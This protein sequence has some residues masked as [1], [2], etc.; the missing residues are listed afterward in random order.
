MTRWQIGNRNLFINVLTLTFLSREWPETGWLTPESP[1]LNVGNHPCVMPSLSRKRIEM[2]QTV[3]WVTFSFISMRKRYKFK[4]TRCL[5]TRTITFVWDNSFLL[6]GEIS[7][8]KN[9]VVVLKWQNRGVLVFL[10][11]SDFS[12][13]RKQTWGLRKWSG[14][15]QF[16][17]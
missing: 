2:N 5:Q 14:N 3:T 7:S 17:C 13:E 15:R 10:K 12:P 4:S 6:P 9:S 1:L 11:F 8:A 16:Q